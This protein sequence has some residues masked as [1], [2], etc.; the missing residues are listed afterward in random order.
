MHSN[1]SRRLPLE[2]TPE[3]TAV[4]TWTL[5]IGQQG[6]LDPAGEFGFGDYTVLTPADTYTRRRFAFGAGGGAAE[7][8]RL[9]QA[10][11]AATIAT[12]DLPN[13]AS[14]APERWT[15]AGPRST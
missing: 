2:S 15:A 9:A 4:R 5:G 7:N 11:L 8:H 13:T 3:L 10:V 12:S 1:D 14:Q 6:R